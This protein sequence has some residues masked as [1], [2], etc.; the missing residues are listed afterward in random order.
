MQI[1]YNHQYVDP[2]YLRFAN[3]SRTK[4]RRF[5]I[6]RNQDR[7]IIEGDHK[8]LHN[9]AVAYVLLIIFVVGY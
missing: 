6:H 9:F 4:K 1:E 2:G 8:L 5:S 3:R 7:E